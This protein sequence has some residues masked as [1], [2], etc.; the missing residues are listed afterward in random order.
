MLVVGSQSVLGTYGEFE[1][2][3]EATYSEEADVFPLFDD[4]DATLS[5][6][7]DGVMGEMSKF[8]ET[9]GFYAQGVDRRTALLSA[10]WERRLVPIRNENTRYNTG[11]CLDVHDMCAAK[12]L[13]NREKDRTF[14]RALIEEDL[15]L[16]STIRERVE[17]T[18]V[19][20]ARKEIALVW[21]DGFPAEQP[22]YHAPDLPEVPS[23]WPNHP[24][25]V[26]AE[27]DAEEARARA[28]EKAFGG[29]WPHAQQGRGQTGPGPSPT[30]RF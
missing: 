14:V 16:A 13:A 12:L 17:A 18:E 2:P 24:A 1:L 28:N 5:T 15:V 23:D 7:I 6:Q 11:W 30:V 9:H 20:P 27:R 21:L 25:D 22:K 8:H 29:A 26:F 3:E 10:G 19:D 4:T